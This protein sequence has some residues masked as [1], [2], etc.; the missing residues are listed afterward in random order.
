MNHDTDNF[1]ALKPRLL[2]IA[3]RMLG[4]RADAEDAVQDAYLRSHDMQGRALKSVDAWV[5]TILTN[6]C[7]DRLRRAKVEREAYIGPWLPEPVVGPPEQSP[8]FALDMA[9]EISM[10]FMVV[11]E[12]LGP[13]ERAVFLLHQVFDYDHSEIA[14]SLGKSEAACRQILHRARQRVRQARPRFEVDP[15]LHRRLVMDFVAAARTGDQQAMLSLLSPEATY[16]ADG[17]G[18]ATAVIKVVRGADKI[19]RLHAGLARKWGSHATYEVAII[20]GEAGVLRR[21]DGNMDSTI[22]FSMAADRID[23]I[24]VVRNPEKLRHLVQPLRE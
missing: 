23:A 8:D 9:N 5:V 21:Y 3:Y 15:A 1:N 11:L 4:S 2:R 10:A 14:S 7:I 22:S 13:E 16:T 19:A 6:L 18:K 24:Y 12:R 20:N 17:G